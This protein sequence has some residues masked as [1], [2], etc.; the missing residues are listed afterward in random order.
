M[1]LDSLCSRHWCLV[2]MDAL[3]WIAVAR[4]SAN[5]MIE[6]N[7][8]LRARNIIQQQLLDL[9][10]VYSAYP[11]IVPEVCFCAL[12]VLICVERVVIEIE[13]LFLTAQ[14]IQCYLFPAVAPVSLRYTWER[15]DVVVGR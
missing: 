3:Y 7:N 5:C 11:L 12:D 15:L 2:D 14:V 8:S 10:V 6:Q 1:E 9:R 13:H 4:W